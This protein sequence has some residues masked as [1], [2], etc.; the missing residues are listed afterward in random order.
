MS[1]IEKG[2]RGAAALLIA[3]RM[4]LGKLASSSGSTAPR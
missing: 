3:N 2:S 1:L 4:L